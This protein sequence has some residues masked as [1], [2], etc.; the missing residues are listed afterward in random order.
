[1][2]AINRINRRI[3]K[4]PTMNSLMTNFIAFEP[5][6]PRNFDSVA[7]F[8]PRKKIRDKMVYPTFEMP[9]LALERP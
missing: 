4:W 1:L 5:V 9:S 3:N 2:G 8:V 6:L 7:I